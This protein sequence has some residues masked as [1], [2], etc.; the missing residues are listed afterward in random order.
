[1]PIETNNNCSQ[2]GPQTISG[3]DSSGNS[4]CFD[5][6][7]RGLLQ[8]YVLLDVELWGQRHRHGNLAMENNKLV[9]ALVIICLDLKQHNLRVQIPQQQHFN[10]CGT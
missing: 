7:M 5:E 2:L 1:M 9:D 4:A 10:L 3:H 8:V 6:L